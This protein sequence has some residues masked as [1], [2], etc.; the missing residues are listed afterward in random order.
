MGAS[1][2][3]MPIPKDGHRLAACANRPLCFVLLIAASLQVLFGGIR[4]VDGS[5]LL[6]F[7]RFGF[8]A[9]LNDFAQYLYDSPLKIIVLHALYLESVSL[10]GF[11]FIL[12]NFL[13]LAVIKITPTARNESLVVLAVIT[14][15]PIWKLMFQNV[16]IGDSVIISTTMIAAI[17]SNYFSVALGAIV[18]VLWHFQQGVIIGLCLSTMF[19]M[20]LAK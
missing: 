20:T 4:C 12:I 7:S 8:G 9:E 18:A 5:M 6:Q 1:K 13:P 11:V 10:I 2:S 16:G 3:E 14:I 17:S 19:A 15:L